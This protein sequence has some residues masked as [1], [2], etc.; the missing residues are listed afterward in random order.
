M[1]DRA[2]TSNFRGQAT[3]SNNEQ[4]PSHFTSRRAP[5]EQFRISESENAFWTRLPPF[6]TLPTTTTPPRCCIGTFSNHAG[7]FL[8]PTESL[9][10]TTLV[11]SSNPR[12]RWCQAP[13]VF[14]RLFLALTAYSN[15]GDTGVIDGALCVLLCF[16]LRLRLGSLRLPFFVGCRWPGVLTRLASRILRVHYY[17]CNDSFDDRSCSCS[18][19]ASPFFRHPSFPKRP[20]GGAS[21]FFLLPFENA[22]HREDGA[23][24]DERNVETAVAVEG[25]G[26][27][28][29]KF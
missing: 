23:D 10:Q 26:V 20:C 27:D 11:T 6:D 14:L 17:A 8:K 2:S 29:K 25:E 16:L 5:N 3:L 7:H 22:D 24:D 18:G 21:A 12:R 15:N 4:L 19:S 28:I 13:L 9:S 1:L